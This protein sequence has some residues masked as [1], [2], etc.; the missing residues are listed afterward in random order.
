LSSIFFVGKKKADEKADEGGKS[1]KLTSLN[2]WSKIKSKFK[3]RFFVGFPGESSKN[4]RNRT[5]CPTYPLRL[6]EIMAHKASPGVVLSGGLKK[7]RIP[8]FLGFTRFS[9]LLYQHSWPQHS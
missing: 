2:L 3:N 5:N 8:A 6:V 9:I 1:N 4:R 7:L